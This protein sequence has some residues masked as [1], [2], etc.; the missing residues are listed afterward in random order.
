MQLH[1]P[2]ECIHAA[3]FVVVCVLLGSA[4]AGNVC[5]SCLLMFWQT[6]YELGAK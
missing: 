6:T 1:G 3:A 4:H 2:P 5:V